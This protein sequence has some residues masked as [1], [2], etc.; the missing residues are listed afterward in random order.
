MATGRQL[1][2]SFLIED[3]SRLL[4][5]AFGF[6]IS[7]MFLVFSI[8][9]LTGGHMNPA[10]S[11]MMVLKRQ[12]SWT[13]MFSYWLAQFVGAMLG[14][15]L[16]WG[17]VSGTQGITHALGGTVDR[18]P[19]ALGATTLDPVIT[20]GNGFI[21]EFMGS[22][23][24]YFVIAQTALD[25]RGLAGSMFPSIPIGFSLIVVHLGLIPFTG[26]GTFRSC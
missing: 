14:A 16:V 10:V 5:I 23:V 13:R 7:I 20:P 1:S 4:P 17:A 25:K 11:L 24:F 18:P 8:G 12:I 15:S 3:I 26:C 21:L 2:T 9:H 22:F 19:L 6:G